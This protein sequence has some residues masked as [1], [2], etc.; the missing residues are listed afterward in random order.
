MRYTKPIY[1]LITI[2]I[3][4]TLPS[5]GQKKQFDPENIFVSPAI[6]IKRVTSINWMKDGKNYTSKLNNKIIRYNTSSGEEEA[7][8]FDGDQHR[9]RINDYSLS[10]DESQ[11]LL[12]TKKKKIYRRSYTA[13]YYIYDIEKKKLMELS[14]KGAQ[15]YATFS[16]DGSKVAFA[17]NN[18]LFY[19][20]LA[21][22]E[23][24]QITTNGQKNKIIN[25][26]TD[27][28]YEEEFAFVKA[29]EW[30]P[31]GDKIAYYE[32]DESE[33]PRYNMQLWDSLYPSDYVF[34]Y[35]KAGE[36]NSDISIYIYHLKNKSKVKASMDG[37]VDF[38]I[39]RMQ[40][41]ANNDILS[42]IRLDRLQ[43]IFEI[44][45]IGAN[46]G[47]SQIELLERHKQ[48]FDINFCDDLYY[49]ENGKEFIYSSEQSGYKHFWIYN[50]EKKSLDA[51]TKG[52][53][54]VDELIGIDEKSKTLYFTSTEDSHL[55]RQFYAI[56]FNGKGKT[57]LSRGE[58]WHSIDMSDDCAFYI[59]N[60]SKPGMPP[61]YSLHTSAGKLV[62]VLEDN[63]IA[64][65]TMDSFDWID[66]DFISMNI[67]DS[68]ELY[69]YI[70]KPSNFDS[71]KSYPL[72]M[73]LYGGPGDQEVTKNWDGSSRELYNKMLVQ[74][75]YIV[76]CF[77]NRGT[78]GRGTKF[79]K[80]TY[81]EL[82]KYETID[83]IEIARKLGEKSYIDEKRIGIWGWSYGGFMST[84]CLFKGNDV[85]KLAIAVA[86]VTNWRFY[87]NIYTE[88]YM[89]RPKDN[90]SGYDDNSPINF[91]DGLKGKYLL[92]HGT[93]DDNVH[94]QNA[95]ELQEKLIKLGKQ[96]DS[97]Y[98]PGS[99][100]SINTGGAQVH[101]H[102]LMRNFILN[103]L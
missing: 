82:G 27:W 59:D 21:T 34:K 58:S 89:Q 42:L 78:G 63:A 67:F 75:G 62:K 25:G 32:F 46:S 1:L 96:F 11:I 87:D 7:T 50:T 97:F 13:E 72:M 54:E 69:G 60:Y 91:A 22:G 102:T 74:N 29:F 39:P 70:M 10:S 47:M 30:S 51:I 56:G 44:V 40:W 6:Q 57:K 83:Q 88:R 43:Q 49:L 20:D 55:E 26:T 9:I 45:H 36:K 2:L 73:F 24:I 61:K 93:A 99:S 98:Y 16:P 41:T 95:V 90:A 79:K 33:V 14:D 12:E 66:K 18:N 8:L 80:I 23:E 92:I 71:T 84:S 85:F 53:W 77:D 101:V 64:K 81:K 5:Q 4:F 76:A 38:Y 37:R 68:V 48:Y 35:P 15:Q 3:C 100:H 65:K 17:R 103:N 31:K 94:F 52:K 19:K 86:P 28:V